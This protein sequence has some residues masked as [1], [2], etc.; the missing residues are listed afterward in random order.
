MH[1]G[2][3]TVGSYKISLSFWVGSASVFLFIWTLASSFLF[4]TTGVRCMTFNPDGKTLLCGLHESLK[5]SAL[6]FC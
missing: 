6:V 5:V 3:V 1:H 4:Q 2:F